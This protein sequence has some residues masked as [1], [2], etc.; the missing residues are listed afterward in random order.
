VT[1][2]TARRGAITP[3]DPIRALRRALAGP[4]IRWVK[5]GYAVLAVGLVCSPTAEAKN[6]AWKP[7]VVVRAGYSTVPD[8]ESR[9]RVLK[10]EMTVSTPRSAERFSMIIDGE[11]CRIV[12]KQSP[13]WP[14]ATWSKK[15]PVPGV[16]E[17][18]EY[19][20][21]GKTVYFRRLSQKRVV[22]LSLVTTPPAR[23]VTSGRR[24][25]NP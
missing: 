15:I 24:A 11:N 10:G 7:G 25:R 3:F 22:K 8:G 23:G 19:C 13:Y 18:I 6:C 12:A 16:D 4:G 21:V 2:S 1:R 5:I 9:T 14:W 17:H 20:V